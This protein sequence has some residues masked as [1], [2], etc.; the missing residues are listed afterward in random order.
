MP[1][2]FHETLFTDA[3]KAHQTR[4]GSRASYARGEA[5]TEPVHQRLS[6]DEVAFITARDSFYLASVG[7]T[8]WP[9]IQ[10]RGGPPGFITALDDATLGFADYRGNRQYI[11]LGNTDGNDR[12]A[13]FFMD[14]AR[15]RR[16]KLIGR[17]RV[18][19]DTETLARLP[20]PGD[21]V[22]V[23]RGL[24][25]HV[26]GFDWNCPQHITQR[27][28]VAEIEAAVAPLHQRIAE[29]EAALAARG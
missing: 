20:A 13:L 8:G 17:L 16:L 27:Y 5:I 29:L 15:R 3:V 26:T 12:V 6:D 24:L 10:H 4:A 9:Y 19:A 28:T 22:R 21:G 14:Y 23:E 1:H 18:V 7:A 11:T 2:L 25:I